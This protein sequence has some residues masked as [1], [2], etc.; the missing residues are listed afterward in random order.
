MSKSELALQ[1]VSINSP[2]A[3]AKFATVLKKFIVDR[4]LYVTIKGKNY[5][6]VEGWEFAGASIGVFPL[7]KETENLSAGNELK[8]RA[9]VELVVLASGKV[10][11]AGEAIC[12]NKE[13]GKGSYDEYAIFS[14]AQTRAIGKAY[15]NAFAWLMKMAGY[16]PTPAEEAF[17]APAEPEV[18][19]PIEDVKKRV[20]AKLDTMSSVEKIKA[21]KSTRHTSTKTLSDV[22]WRRLDSEL[23]TDKNA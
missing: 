1:K 11:G 12:S 9:R 4:N 20:S 21:L 8:F 23:G 13:H 16:E 7:V 17:E 14:M 15:R 19:D 3:L 2:Q 10:M 18:V 22:D 6:Q 5:V